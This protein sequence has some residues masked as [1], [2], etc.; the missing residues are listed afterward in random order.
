MLT[1]LVDKRTVS[2]VSPL[3]LRQEV[4][5]EV[6]QSFCLEYFLLFKLSQDYVLPD[7]C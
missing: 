7:L 2:H 5:Y 3:Y 4:R 6:K 1:F